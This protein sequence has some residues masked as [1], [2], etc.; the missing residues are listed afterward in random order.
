MSSSFLLW[1][2][3]DHQF[4]GWGLSASRKVKKKKKIQI[5]SD[6][7]WTLTNLHDIFR[8]CLKKKQ[9]KKSQRIDHTPPAYVHFNQCFISTQ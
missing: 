2:N 3:K 9:K 1:G 8:T 5:I 6:S 4:G 7:K